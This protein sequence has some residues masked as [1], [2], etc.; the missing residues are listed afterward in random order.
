MNICG[1]SRWELYEK[2]DISGY[3]RQGDNE[4]VTLHLLHGNGF[5]SGSLFALADA[6][7][8]AWTLMAS[9]LPGHGLTPVSEGEWPDWNAMADLLAQNVVSEVGKP[10]V[11]VGHSLGGIITLLMAAKYPSLF[12]QVIL[13]DP[14]LFPPHI[15]VGQRVIH[16][17]GLW[18][19]LPLV[20]KAMKRQSA[21]DSHADMARSLKGKSLYK[22]WHPVALDGF[23]KTGSR[24]NDQGVT[25]ACAPSWEAK[26]FGSAPAGLWGA[27]Q[28]LKVPTHILV[29]DHGFDF[30]PTGVKR[31]QRLNRQVSSQ[32]FGGSHCFPMEKPTET[33]RV[34]QDIL[35][36]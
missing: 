28:S 24:V 35:S 18:G 26:I 29:A 34:I 10:V 14:V 21:W 27:V 2:V 31:A 8:P 22:H 30:I 5:S 17:T 20:K 19:K 12:S 6:M 7:P 4:E 9:D 15:L 11:G 23:C 1:T 33:A 13:L 25:L 32:M 36:A 16:K 3:L